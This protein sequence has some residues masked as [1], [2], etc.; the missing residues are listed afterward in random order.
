MVEDKDAIIARLIRERDEA[1]EQG[2]NAALRRGRTLSRM[3]AELARLESALAA[4]RE[5]AIKIVQDQPY[6]P[7]T[8]T[9]MRQQWVK[10]Q[11]IEKLRASLPAPQEESE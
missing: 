2:A 6:Y 11:I 3:R 5:A 7:D 1:R 10:D 9:G 4:A 8:H